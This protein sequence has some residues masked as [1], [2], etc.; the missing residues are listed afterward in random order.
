MKNVLSMFFFASPLHVSK[1]YYV[2]H[3]YNMYLFILL[4][5]KRTGRPIFLRDGH[6]H[7]LVRMEGVCSIFLGYVARLIVFQVK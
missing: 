4:Y 7:V 6:A 2:R 1:L 3:L 5:F